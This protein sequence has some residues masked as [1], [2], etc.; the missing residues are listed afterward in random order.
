MGNKL[1]GHSLDRI[2]QTSTKQSQNGVPLGARLVMGLAVD[3]E[4]S[5][6]FLDAKFGRHIMSN[7]MNIGRT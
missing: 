1:E 6:L 3:P 7:G 5:I 4:K 2:T